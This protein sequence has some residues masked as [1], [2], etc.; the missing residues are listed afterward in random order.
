MLAIAE[1]APRLTP[2]SMHDPVDE[3]EAYSRA[4]HPSSIAFLAPFL[5]DKHIATFCHPRESYVAILSTISY[6]SSSLV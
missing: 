6:A 4:N 1:M 5:V 2:P 3:F